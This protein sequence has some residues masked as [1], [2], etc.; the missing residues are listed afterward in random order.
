MTM[1]KMM[2]RTSHCRVLLDMRILLEEVKH[3]KKVQL[4]ARTDPIMVPVAIGT[5]NLGAEEEAIGADQEEIGDVVTVGEEGVVI[6]TIEERVT[7]I[8][9]HRATLYHHM[10][11]KMGNMHNHSRVQ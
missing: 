8:L 9:K 3:S 6:K 11:D 2:A 7:G 5:V 1:L 10:T 4:V